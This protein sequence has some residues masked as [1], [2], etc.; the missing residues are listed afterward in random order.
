MN[1]KE[2]E[3]FLM[4]LEDKV[5]ECYKKEVSFA[6]KEFLKEYENNGK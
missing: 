6:I 4:Y 1:K 2:L 5:Q 3:K